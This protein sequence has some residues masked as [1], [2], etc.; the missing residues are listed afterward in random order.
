MPE[1][2]TILLVDDDPDCRALSH[3]ALRACGYGQ[4][5]VEARSGHEALGCLRRVGAWAAAP[6]MDLVLLDVEMPGA[7][8]LEV[9]AEIKADPNLRET[10]VVMLTGLDDAEHRE[11][12]MK[13][14]A[15][16]YVIKSTN[17]DELAAALG[18]VVNRLLG[19]APQDAPDVTP[20]EVGTGAARPYP[21][22]LI[23]EDDEDQRML[24]REAL[25][26]HYGDPS[27]RN[28]VDVGTASECL[29]TDLS[30]FEIVL[31]DYH[32]PDMPGLDLLEAVL[33]RA[34]LPVIFVTGENDSAT[35]AQA[36]QRGA[37]DYVVKLGDYL[38]AL[39]VL[40]DKNIGQHQIRKDNERL[41]REAQ[42]M[43]QQLQEKNRQLEESL[44]KLEEMAGTDPVT[45]LGNRR[46]FNELLQRYYAEAVRYGFDL[47]CC[48]CDLD[49][50]KDFNDTFGHRVGDEILV[51][52]ARIIRATL[53]SSD[54]A[55]RYGGDEFVLLLPHTSEDRA[56]AV[57]QRVREDLVMTGREYGSQDPAL[58]LSMGIA[59]LSADQPASADEL[60]IMADR[61]LYAA[62]A[63]GRDQTIV[64][65]FASEA[66][67]TSA[68]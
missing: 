5:V 7:T 19:P 55:A 58:G 8:G 40:V 38:F 33:A 29:E 64:Y 61:A 10:R 27:G 52:A 51:S 28:I 67:P 45:G 31:Q 4:R 25:C 41:Q 49:H 63:A 17:S 53:R 60:V 12:A 56:E 43:L 14:G 68:S 50:F 42:D 30:R 66:A 20:G 47:T 57:G 44:Q 35:A 21:G 62:K 32:L 9:L 26:I 65:H 39:P 54:A 24:I 59:S 13:I 22:I 23:V 11:H 16:G 3:E 34:D 36:I 15:F 48:M 1:F 6:P 37:Q 2:N 46:R 18:E